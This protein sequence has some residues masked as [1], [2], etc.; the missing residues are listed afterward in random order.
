[1]SLQT[2]AILTKPIFLLTSSL[3]FVFRAGQARTHF[4]SL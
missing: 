1:M 2:D 4:F 3:P